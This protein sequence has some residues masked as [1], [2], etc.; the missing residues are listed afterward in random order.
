MRATKHIL[1]VGGVL[2]QENTVLLV[3]VQYGPNKGRWML[4]GGL[5]EE[6]ESIE[7]AVVREAHEETGL[8]TR[9]DGIIG[10]RSGV[11]LSGETT[12]YVAFR[13]EDPS[14][15]LQPADPGE[16]AQASF[17]PIP[18]VLAEPR[19]VDLT[20]AF[21]RSALSPDHGLC[22]EADPIQTGHSYRSYAVYRT[23]AA[24]KD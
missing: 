5:V 7:A 22:R 3:Q 6:G 23:E 2:F 18:A 11:T 17:L 9:P 13:L 15:I 4:P 21:V 12:I 24:Y 1:S 20:K 19:V 16:I 8:T 14:G 10:L